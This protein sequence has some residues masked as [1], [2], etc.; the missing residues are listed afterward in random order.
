MDKFE[1]TCIGNAILDI[2]TEVNDDFLDYFQLTKGSMQ[3]IDNIKFEKIFKKINKFQLVSGGSAANTSVGFSSLGGKAAFIGKIGNDEYGNHFKKGILKENVYFNYEPDKIE[4]NITSKSIILITPDAERTMCTFLGTSAILNYND[5]DLNILKK[6]KIVYLEGYLYDNNIT[7]K[8]IL[9]IC[10]FCNKNKILICLSLSDSFCVN[11]HKEDFY[12]MIRNHVDVIFGNEYEIKS[13]F[14]EILDVSINNLQKLVSE[15]A[16]TLGSKGSKVF[17]KKETILVESN[18]KV[19]VKDT[20][21]AGDL[22]A[23]GYLFGMSKQFS[24][25]Q[26]G[27]L[28]SKTAEEIISHFGARPMIKLSKLI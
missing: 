20:T 10:K 28:A 14:G 13:L 18:K 4:D 5:I 16:I 8:T 2:V 19:S 23:A 24:L 6:S 9:D 7:K 25:L 3:I 11:R 27:K 12:N 1:L 22:F 15:G 26:R 17:D 21:G